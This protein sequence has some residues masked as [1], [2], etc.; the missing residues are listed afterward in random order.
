MAET[1]MAL[2]KYDPMFD[3]WADIIEPELLSEPEVGRIHGAGRLVGP[4]A[5]PADQMRRPWRHLSVGRANRTDMVSDEEK[6]MASLM[7]SHMEAPKIEWN[8]EIDPQVVLELNN[9]DIEDIKV[10][11]VDY[12]L[13]VYAEHEDRPEEVGHVC[14]RFRRRYNLPRNVNLDEITV[15]FSDNR[16]LVV[17]APK[18]PINKVTI[19]EK[20]RNRR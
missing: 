15:T 16:T 9:F 11:Q 14:R 13:E 1:S 8:I 6:F 7:R 3:T 4:F 20:R 5:L 17:T 12:V 18:R 10:K 19:E 2:W